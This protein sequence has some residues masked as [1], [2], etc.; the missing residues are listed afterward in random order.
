[1]VFKI[2]FSISG[3][4]TVTTSQGAIFIGGFDGSYVATVACYNHA[5]WS[6]L[7]DLQSVRGYHR[8]II[9]GDKVYVVGGANTK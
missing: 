6:K 2:Y 9:N 7:D 4:G 8:A 1:M 5:G 3:Y